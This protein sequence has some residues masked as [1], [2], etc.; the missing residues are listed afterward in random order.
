MYDSPSPV[1][2]VTMHEKRALM[3]DSFLC[4]CTEH[5]KIFSHLCSRNKGKYTKPCLISRKEADEKQILHKLNSKKS[6]LFWK[7][8]CISEKEKFPEI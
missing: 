7:T 4:F 1:T 6:F 5:K 3:I 8:F 2:L